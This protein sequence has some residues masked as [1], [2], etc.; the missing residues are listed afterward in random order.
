MFESSGAG[1]FAARY[2]Q[3]QIGGLACLYRGD[4]PAAFG[5]DA[6]LFVCLRFGNNGRPLRPV[7]VAANGNNH[8]YLGRTCRNVAENQFHI[9]Q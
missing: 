7:F 5:H 9:F 4:Q 8:G 2:R 3:D 6:V 1:L